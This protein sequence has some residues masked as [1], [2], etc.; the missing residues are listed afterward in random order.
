MSYNCF[1]EVVSL[2]EKQ[3]A[4]TLI[5]ML[6][7][8]DY[9]PFL[10]VSPFPGY[11]GLHCHDFFEFYLFF[12]GA[13]YYCI[14]DQTFPLKPCTLAI[15]PPF[16]MHGLVG[17]EADTAYERA[18]MYVTPAMVRKISMGVSNLSEFFGQCVQAGKAYFPICYETAQN[19][20]QSIAAVKAHAGDTGEISKWQNDLR[21]ANFLSDVYDIAQAADISCKP[22]ILNESIQAILTYLN[23]H[24]CERISI[25]ELSRRF[26]ISAS[27]MTREFTAYTG[28]SV[29]DYVLYRR[30][31]SAKE[32]ICAGMPFTQ[33]AYAC[34]FNDYSC[35]LRAFI[36]S[37]GQS[38]TAYK[39]YIKSIEKIS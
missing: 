22:V 8:A 15:I 16:H 32:K 2:D 12:S 28:R 7:N 20:R 37:V 3:R 25:P 13:P 29:Y 23:D 10:G 27:C 11:R 33:T 18:W 19:L 30:I 34:G 38:P 6:I 36:K 5:P 4:P 17:A 9:E 14:G 21:V 39:K 26:G 1:S 31:L 24:Y 35:F